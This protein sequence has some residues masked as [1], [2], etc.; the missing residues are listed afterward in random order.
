MDTGITDIDVIEKEGA[1]QYQLTVDA[2]GNGYEVGE[3]VKQQFD[4]YDMRGVV[5]TFT[6]DTKTLQVAHA[7]ATDGKFHTFATGVT[8][9][10]ESSGTSQTLTAV[11][12]I[13]EIQ[14]DAQ[15]QIFD[16]FEADF[17][18]FSESNP[19]GDL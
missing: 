16:D 11:A 17:L 18:D 14:Q 12:E 19:F 10:G 13:Q 2:A 4:G 15:N 9:T 8:L 3:Y 7:G 1:F 6:R 5:T